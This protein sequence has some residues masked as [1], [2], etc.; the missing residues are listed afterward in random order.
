[1]QN[2]S[3]TNLSNELIKTKLKLS[4]NENQIE[5]GNE[6]SSKTILETEDINVKK[7]KM[8][9]SQNS[10]NDSISM[11]MNTYQTNYLN[12][13]KVFKFKISKILGLRKNL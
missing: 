12:E 5:Y 10:L 7:L 2:T 4:D 6:M 11:E 1:M 8:K 9:N 3:K 13:K